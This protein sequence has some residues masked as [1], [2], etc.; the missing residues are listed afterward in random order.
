M[1][2]FF[3]V[4]T[5]LLFSFSSVLADDINDGYYGNPGQI[6]KYSYPGQ[7]HTGRYPG[8]Y[9]DNGNMNDDSGNMNDDSGRY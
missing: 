1:K 9:D 4:I 7:I 8:Q 2:T 3:L 5:V 6:D